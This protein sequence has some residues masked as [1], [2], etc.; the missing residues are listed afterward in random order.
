MK[1]ILIFFTVV[2]FTGCASTS[3]YTIH[4]PDINVIRYS[5]IVVF[6][7]F[8]DVSL[9]KT[10]EKNFVEQLETYNIFSCTTLELF[11]PLRQYTCKEVNDKLDSKKIDA[12]LII[13]LADYYEDKVY[14]PQSNTTTSRTKITGNTL[15][16]NTTTTITGGYMVSKPRV[17]FVVNLFDRENNQI[18]WQANTFTRGNAF[19][20]IEELTYSLAQEVVAFYVRESKLE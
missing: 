2:I 16:G 1:K 6:A 15:Y 4:N 9:R 19:A 3:V 13:D 8:Q 11:P 17:K 7:N 12:V 5:K 10:I 14:V 18:A 20:G